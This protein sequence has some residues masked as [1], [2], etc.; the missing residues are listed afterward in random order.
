MARLSLLLSLFLLILPVLSARVIANPTTSISITI[1]KLFSQARDTIRPAVAAHTNRR[2]LIEPSQQ[3]LQA[4]RI[5]NPYSRKEVDQSGY[6][7]N[8]EPRQGKYLIALCV[9]GRLSNQEACLHKYLLLASLLK[10]TLIIPTSGC[11]LPYPVCWHWENVIDVPRMRSCLQP[12][13]GND[14]V[15]SVNEYLAREKKEMLKIDHIACVDNQMCNSHYGK[16]LKDF[17][18]LTLP[19]TLEQTEIPTRTTDV[20]DFLTAYKPYEDADVISV[21]STYY[22]QLTGLPFYFDAWI[23]PLKTACSNIWQPPPPVANF[24]NGFIDTFL[25]ND[26]AALH[27]RRG[28]FAMTYLKEGSTKKTTAFLPIVTVARFITR[29]LK[30]TGVSALY[31]ATDASP[32]EVELLEKLILSTRTE[33]PLI[34]IRL[35]NF[36]T[37]SP[38]Y[39]SFP[40]VNRFLEMDQQDSGVLRALAEKY[41]CA[42]ARFFIGTPKSTFSGDIFRL[43][44]L[45]GHMTDVDAYLGNES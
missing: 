32:F 1:S 4:P 36:S 42:K 44:V 20:S 2:T 10:R 18:N 3:P 35:P 8:W 26:Y 34:V 6:T 13:Y 25:G 39:S 14:T 15:I 17:E 23:P 37:S 5:G 22:V 31:L 30:N 12:A 11:G 29:R 21:G 9:L 7:V 45:E 43:R 38:E 27:L 19:T 41:I 40:W 33:D 16:P 24:V 28:D